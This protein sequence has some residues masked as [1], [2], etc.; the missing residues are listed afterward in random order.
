MDAIEDIFNIPRLADVFD[1]LVQEDRVHEVLAEIVRWSRI[2][3]NIESPPESL[4]SVVDEDEDTD[5]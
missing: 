1:E 3:F 2:E 5:D 4:E